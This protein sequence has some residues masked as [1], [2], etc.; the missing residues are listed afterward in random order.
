[1]NKLLSHSHLVFLIRKNLVYKKFDFKYILINLLFDKNK[2]LKTYIYNFLIKKFKKVSVQKSYFDLNY[3]DDIYNKLYGSD[4][5]Y[6]HISEIRAKKIN[7]EK[8]LNFLKERILYVK[9]K[10]K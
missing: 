3:R 8:M 9:V 2:I 6:N 10:K 5:F 7:H 4:F 1:M